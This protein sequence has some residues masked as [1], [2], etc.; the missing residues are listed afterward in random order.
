[1]TTAILFPGQG[2]QRPG[3]RDLV[4]E[5]RP[6][7]LEAAEA[8]AGTDPFARLDEG[9]RYVQPALFCASLAGWAA[10]GDER[11]EATAV[12]GH[13]LGEL[14]AL[15]AA[16]V[17]A[18]ADALSLVVLR[19]RLMDDAGRRAGDGGM[20]AVL[21]DGASEA[22][23]RLAAAHGLVVAN[24]NS[25]VQIV[26]SGPDPG[27]SAAGREARSPELGLRSV[28]LDV[29]G[30]FHSPAMQ[31]AVGP[32]AEALAAAPVA[33]PTPGL[34]LTVWSGVTASP[35]DD[36]RRRIA[37]GLVSPVRWRETVLAMGAA[38]V[39]R[40]VEAGPGRVLTGLVRAT[41]PSAE[42]I[43]A[44]PDRGAARA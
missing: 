17:L 41:L 31:V 43:A 27:L 18:E 29:S 16:G 2:S 38:G 33:A 42:A 24:D 44:A 28:R 39:T 32:F 15:A 11:A 20:L 7:L 6:D 22:G 35:V 10:L 25:P 23:P 40:F 36:P 1:M 30:A 9:T 12:A 19:G 8:A 34:G 21:G 13:S 5:Y 37:E 26:L 14:T 4:A 3:M